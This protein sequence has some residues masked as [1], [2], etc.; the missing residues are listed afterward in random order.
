MLH[1]FS[2]FDQ[3]A[4]RLEMR[5]GLAPYATFIAVRRTGLVYDGAFAPATRAPSKGRIAFH[6]LLNGTFATSTGLAWAGPTLIRLEEE[7]LEGAD[8]GRA[9]TVRTTGDPHVLLAVHVDR[10]LIVPRTMTRGPVAEP[11]SERLYRAAIAVDRLGESDDRRTVEGR[12][13]EVWAA[14]EAD[15]WVSPVPETG[16]ALTTLERIWAALARFTDRMDSGGSIQAFADLVDV[17]PRHANRLLRL[18]TDAYGL[19]NEPWREL[20]RRWRLKLATLLLSAP[21]LSVQVVARR[22][23][24]SNAEALANALAAEGLP[25]PSAYRQRPLFVAPEGPGDR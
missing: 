10:R 19:P 13:Q 20:T 24:Y 9:Y 17:S 25:P 5:F 16:P 6:I 15:G 23:G 14:L 3:G 1:S 22:V 8:G 21:E 4:V 11:L 7:I 2:S 18:F 12:Y